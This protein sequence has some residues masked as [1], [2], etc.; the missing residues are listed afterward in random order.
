[1]M[2]DKHI[3]ERAY[4]EQLDAVG[5]KTGAL[6]ILNLDLPVE[7]WVKEEGIGE[8]DIRERLTEAANAAFTE[9]AE[10]FGDDIM[11]DVVA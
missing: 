8:D 6:N 9:K 2:V 11:H 1:D 10:R 3:P 4:A 7:D 5:L